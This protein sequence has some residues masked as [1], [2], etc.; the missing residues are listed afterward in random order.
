MTEEG[1]ITAAEKKGVVSK[2]D[3]AEEMPPEPEWLF[4]ILSF[5]V[6][7]AGIVIGAIYMGKP[8]EEC[9]RFGKNCIIAA[10][11]RILLYCLCI[12]IYILFIVVY[13]VFYIVL[14][15]V[16]ITFAGLSGGEYA[17]IGALV[18]IA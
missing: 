14:M 9:R 2:M 13:F 8:N 17:F 18:G 11:I 3:A 6:Q 7:I 4:Y 12:Y 10:I 15:M 5:F 1:N 16:V